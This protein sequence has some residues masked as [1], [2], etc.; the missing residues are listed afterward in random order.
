VSEAM[1]KPLIT[2]PQIDLQKTCRTITAFIRT[3]TSQAQTQGVVIGLSGGVDSSLTA[4]LCVRALGHERVLGILMP[5]LFTPHQDTM[6]AYKLARQLQIST[7]YVNI[8]VISEAFQ[9][10]LAH[11]FPA[12]MLKKSLANIRARIRMIILYYYAN[13][14]NFLVAGTSD[15]SEILIG[16]YTK[17]GDGGADFLPIG[18]LY[19]THVRALARYLE[20][21]FTI[22]AKPSSPQL[23]P[24]HKLADE[25]PLDYPMIDRILIGSLN[26]QLS[27]HEISQRLKLPIA[28]VQ[29]ILDRIDRSTHKRNPLPVLSPDS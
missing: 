20:I 27:T 26:L 19:K 3:I 14:N 1:N 10:Q 16:F 9:S 6:D 2:I 12:H 23:Y 18:H 24:G 22:A 8:H 17:Y 5:T 25:L 21:P 29:N 28:Q 11:G 7:Q 15:R 13:I 4:A